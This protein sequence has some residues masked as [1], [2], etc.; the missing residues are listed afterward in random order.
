MSENLKIHTS[1]NSQGSPS[2]VPDIPISLR[3]GGSG[4]MDFGDYARA[5]RDRWIW[6]VATLLLCL[7]L[8][9]AITAAM[10]P[11]YGARATLFVT[12]NSPGDT[13][14]AQSQFATQ[15]VGSYPQLVNNPEIL[16]AVIGE[17]KL[18]MSI[19]ELGASVSATNPTGTVLVQV[20]AQASKPELAAAI[21]NSM[22]S[23]MAKQ[24]SALESGSE[25]K[26]SVVPILSVPALPPPS[27]DSPRQL[28][29]YLIGGL[30]GVCGGLV[31]ALLVDRLDPRVFRAR[32]VERI[33][34]VRL[35]GEAHARPAPSG[36]RIGAEVR[37]DYR[38][39][40]SNL[41]MVNDGQIPR[42]IL[43]LSCDKHSQIDATKFAAVLS[44][45]G[46][47]VCLIEGDYESTP[48]LDQSAQGPGVSQVLGTHLTVD[49]AVNN[50]EELPLGYLSA[51]SN[52]LPLRDFDVYQRVPPMLNELEK[53]YDVILVV[54]RLDV[55][56][57]DGSVIAPFTDCVIV[58]C[59]A[60][61]TWL[62]RIRLTLRELS[63][64]R[65]GTTGILVMRPNRWWKR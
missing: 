15:R 28:V 64:I 37:N 56:P 47:R 52:L 60:R 54:T 36:T 18:D 30:L 11:V 43:F 7:G 49:S 50:I 16:Q 55:R 32:D 25:S 58:T 35:L 44:G 48:N 53:T 4:P 17:L 39:L 19:A 14:Y 62:R 3:T 12:V 24:V 38:Q 21:A 40:A 26:L 1:R 46:Q 65:A 22:A 59:K 6:V 51:G 34:G 45:M 42:R 57:L 41:L 23:K 8:S 2:G 20:K 29:N 9:A 63:A 10:T 61:K 13:A 33:F 27:P 31:V 5:I